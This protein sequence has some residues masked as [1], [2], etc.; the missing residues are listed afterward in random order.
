MHL[1]GEGS[2]AATGEARAARA[3]SPRARDCLAELNFA[4][5]RAG[6]WPSCKKSLKNKRKPCAIEMRVKSWPEASTVRSISSERLVLFEGTH[7]SL[8]ARRKPA[9]C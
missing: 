7:T 8:R 5:R 4:G 9:T 3:A 2:A 1:I 6:H